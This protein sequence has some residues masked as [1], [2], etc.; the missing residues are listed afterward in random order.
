MKQLTKS[1]IFKAA[2]RMVRRVRQA[3]DDYRAT[4]GLCLSFMAAN[5]KAAARDSRLDSRF[6]KWNGK[7]LYF[8]SRENGMA[9]V[10]LDLATKKWVASGRGSRAVLEE[11]KAAYAAA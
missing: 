1:A 11:A 3:G 10:Y 8:N 4:F 5:R 6:N 2:H 9:T 7:R